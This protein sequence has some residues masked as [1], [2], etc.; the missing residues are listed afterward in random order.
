MLIRAHRIGFEVND[1]RTVR[2]RHDHVHRALDDP[3]GTGRGEWD[4]PV[5]PRARRESTAGGGQRRPDE[6]DRAL[7]DGIAQ[8][9]LL[10]KVRGKHLGEVGPVEGD[11]RQDGVHQRAQRAAARL[12]FQ[13]APQGFQCL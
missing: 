1:R 11:R 9:C 6:D 13:S 4:L 7:L 8:T 10:C 5:D 3:L 12:E 2:S